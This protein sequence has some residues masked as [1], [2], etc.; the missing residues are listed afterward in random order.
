LGQAG[1][2]N[3]KD[4]GLKAMRLKTSCGYGKPA[5]AAYKAFINESAIALFLIDGS[6]PLRSMA[7]KLDNR[8]SN[9]NDE[10]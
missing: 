9:L 2:N 7:I 4:A 8:E 1:W 6:D 5:E 3:D 10:G